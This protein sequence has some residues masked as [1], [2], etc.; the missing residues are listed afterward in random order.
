M[1]HRREMIEYCAQVKPAFGP[2]AN[3]EPK[4]GWWPGT[5]AGI[6]SNPLH[7]SQTGH[8]GLSRP[9]TADLAF[10]AI[11]HSVDPHVPPGRTV[12]AGLALACI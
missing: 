2:A 9:G 5:P 10:E 1:E 7:V 6:P 3:A 8:R 12:H 11:D 4:Y